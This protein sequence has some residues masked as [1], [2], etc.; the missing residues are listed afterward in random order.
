[1]NRD[2]IGFSIGIFLIFFASFSVGLSVILN[3]DIL[4]LII[5]IFTFSAGLF[6]IFTTKEESIYYG[7]EK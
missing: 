6:L 4:Y 1:M 5:G 3:F 2:T 7:V